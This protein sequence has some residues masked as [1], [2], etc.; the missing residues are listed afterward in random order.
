MSLMDGRAQVVFDPS[1]GVGARSMI[2][3]LVSAGFGAS[4]WKEAESSAAGA[5]HR[6]ATVCLLLL[7]RAFTHTS[8]GRPCL[9]LFAR[10]G[11]VWLCLRGFGGFGGVW[12][13]LQMCRA[14]TSRKQSLVIC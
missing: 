5:S 7:L 1:A 13:C 14:L 4:V 11:S 8:K 3:V 12:L 10:F 6:Y 9:A 2:D